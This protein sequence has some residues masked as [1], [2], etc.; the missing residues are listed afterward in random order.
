[1]DIFDAAGS[2]NIE[3]IEELLNSGINIDTQNCNGL[4]PLMSAVGG[5]KI[6]AVR[7]LLQKGASVKKKDLGG[8]TALDWTIN[9][10]ILDLFSNLEKPAE[11]KLSDIS[12]LS[13][14]SKKLIETLRKYKPSDEPAKNI[15]KLISDDMPYELKALLE[16]MAYSPGAS[17]KVSK[18]Y[19]ESRCAYQAEEI[20]ENVKD[21]G[22]KKRAVVIGNDAGPIELV[23]SWSVKDSKTQ[24]YAV[25][26]EY[27]KASWLETLEK[28]AKSV[29]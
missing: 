4:T 11:I 19:I 3:K 24:I 18:W 13:K 17:V 29:K 14:N 1:M 10:E 28:F 16:T 22:D 6:D 8:R 2:G 15:I 12:F 23:A 27:G 7:F 26:S 20:L 9:K 5:G 21:F 25:D